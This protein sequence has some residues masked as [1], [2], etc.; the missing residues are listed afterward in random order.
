M[1]LHIKKEKMFFTVFARG[2]SL[3]QIFKKKLFPD[4]LYEVADINTYFQSQ[5]IQ[6]GHYVIDSAN[7]KNIFF[8]APPASQKAKTSMM[9]RDRDNNVQF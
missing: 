8:M 7:E 3:F 4:G 2:N 1:Y 5:M 9:F 6:N